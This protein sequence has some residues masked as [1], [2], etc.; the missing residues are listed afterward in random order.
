MTA[1]WDA[2]VVGLYSR[3]LAGWFLHPRIKAVVS[4]RASSWCWHHRLR[5]VALWL[6]ARSIKAA[7][8]EI[9][10]RAEI[11]PGL[12]INHTVGI[13]IG[14]EVRAGRDLVLHQGV[15]LGHGPGQGQPIIG[16]NVRIGAG[17]TV[18]GPVRIGHRVII[19][20]GAIVLADV[21]DDTTVVGIWKVKA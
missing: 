11:G 13:V 4:Y 21:P 9:H 7:G 19:G 15:T 12:A 14:H 5:V 17:A 10:P 6:Q 1:A 2:S 20:A 8:I 16:D 3:A 18:L